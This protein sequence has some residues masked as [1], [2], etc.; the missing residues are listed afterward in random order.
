M[1]KRLCDDGLLLRERSP[2]DARA[3]ALRVTDAG[4]S[5]L[6]AAGEP[7][8]TIYEAIGS[9]LDVRQVRNLREMLD[10]VIDSFS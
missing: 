8:D 4:R 6:R 5:V 9:G 7:F 10:R 3:W 2:V 1:V